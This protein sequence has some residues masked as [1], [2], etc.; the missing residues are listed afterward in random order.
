MWLAW[1]YMLEYKLVGH[2]QCYYAV[3]ISKMAL[4]DIEGTPWVHHYVY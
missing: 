2:R 4:I 3:L 1:Q